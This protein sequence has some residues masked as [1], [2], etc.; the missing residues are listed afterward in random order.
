[1]TREERVEYARAVWKAFED[2]RG[3]YE[4]Q[5]SPA[6]WHILATWMDANIP[7]R[8]VLRALEETGGNGRTLSYYFLPVEQAYRRWKEAVA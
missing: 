7:L 5:M 8:V 4:R 3:G 2:K 6:E 1:M